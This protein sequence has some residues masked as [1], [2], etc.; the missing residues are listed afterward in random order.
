[1]VEAGVTVAIVSGV[2]T[3]IY[4][5]RRGSNERRKSERAFPNVVNDLLQE[6]VWCQRGTVKCK[7]GTFFSKVIIPVLP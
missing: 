3:G 1:M 6:E 7:R 5:G 2:S 4:A